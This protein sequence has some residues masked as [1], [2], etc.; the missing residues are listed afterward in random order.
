MT[1]D[2]KTSEISNDSAKKF[3]FIY[4]YFPDIISNIYFFVC[5]FKIQT[6]EYL[7]HFYKKMTSTRVF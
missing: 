3:Y 1:G 6:E 4:I 2:L 5:N 7:T